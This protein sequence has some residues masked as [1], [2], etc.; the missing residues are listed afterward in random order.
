MQKDG[1]GNGFEIAD[2]LAINFD[3]SILEVHLLLI[4]S[5]LK[6]EL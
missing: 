6:K 5:A 1:Y 3:D 2:S 4:L